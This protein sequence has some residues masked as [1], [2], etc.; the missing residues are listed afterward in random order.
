[1]KPKQMKEGC[2]WKGQFIE[3]YAGCQPNVSLDFNRGGLPGLSR[4]LKADTEAHAAGVCVEYFNEKDMAKNYLV[5]SITLVGKIIP[6]GNSGGTGYDEYAKLLVEYVNGETQEVTVGYY[7]QHVNLVFQQ[8]YDRLYGCGNPERT[9]KLLWDAIKELTYPA[10]FNALPNEYKAPKMAEPKK[11]KI[12]RI[13]KLTPRECFRLMGVSDA[14]I[15]KIQ[16]YPFHQLIEHPSYS[17]EEILAGMTEA[18]K[19]AKMKDI[20][21]ESQQYKM[22]GNSIVVQVLEGIFTQMFR[23]DDDALF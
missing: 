15:D 22:A 8:L 10:D 3:A 5:Q 23:L 7:Y 21:S 19:R 20:V 17:K 13:R 9:H 4:T 12:Y 2:W 11:R 14:D 18:E 6:E 1:M 16:A